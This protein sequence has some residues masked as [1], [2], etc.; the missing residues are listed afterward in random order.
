MSREQMIEYLQRELNQAG[1]M[2]LMCRPFPR[3][4]VEQLLGQLKAM[5]ET[6]IEWGFTPIERRLY[7]ILAAS[8]QVVT[9][10]ELQRKANIESLSSLWVH[11]RRLRLRMEKLKNGRQIYTVRGLGYVLRVTQQEGTKIA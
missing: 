7:Q 4:T 11:M 1:E 10:A 6:P 8:E 2:A 5:I 9:Y 3:K